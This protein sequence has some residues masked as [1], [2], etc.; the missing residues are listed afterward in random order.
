MSRRKSPKLRKG[1]IAV[2]ITT[3]G[4]GRG[5]HFAANGGPLGANL[6]YARLMV[7]EAGRYG[8]RDAGRM[9]QTPCV[10]TRPAD[11]RKA[12]RIIL[13]SFSSIL[14]LTK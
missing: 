9:A 11:G 6:A 4:F 5:S 10:V 12:R 7:H 8:R 13:D 2:Q 1:S 14:E 3:K